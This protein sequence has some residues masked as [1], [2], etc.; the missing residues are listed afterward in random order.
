MFPA[1]SCPGS[2][3]TCQTLRLALK[4]VFGFTDNNIIM[5]PS[6]HSNSNKT[7]FRASI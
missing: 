7:F 6:A 3:Q 2:F 4:L 5:L 1:A